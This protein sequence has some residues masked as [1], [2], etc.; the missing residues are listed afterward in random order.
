MYDK[1][2]IPLCKLSYIRIFGPDKGKPFQASCYHHC[3]QQR[4]IAYLPFRDLPGY[5]YVLMHS[6]CRRF[7]MHRQRPSQHGA[8]KCKHLY[9]HN[10]SHGEYKC[11]HFLDKRRNY[12]IKEANI[13]HTNNRRINRATKKTKRRAKQEYIKYSRNNTKKLLRRTRCQAGESRAKE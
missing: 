3:Y 2:D 9:I 12:A 7:P 6:D 1:M 13:N 8:Y 10:I 5:A 11:K 4:S